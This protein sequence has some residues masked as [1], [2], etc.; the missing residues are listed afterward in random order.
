MA[1]SSEKPVSV[2]IKVEEYKNRV[3]IT[4][5]KNVSYILLHL[6]DGIKIGE[7]MRNIGQK[8]LTVPPEGLEPK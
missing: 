6:E 2:D 4:F 8:I 3:L 7:V 1:E 5:N